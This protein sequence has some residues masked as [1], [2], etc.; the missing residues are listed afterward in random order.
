MYLLVLPRRKQQPHAFPA[1]VP[2]AYHQRG[3]P[4]RQGQAPV[5]CHAAHGTLQSATHSA[6]HFL[7]RLGRDHHG[8]AKP[9]DTGK[10]Q[11]PT[12]P[13]TS[14]AAAAAT[15]LRRGGGTGGAARGTVLVLV[16]VVVVLV[17]VLVVVVVVVVVIASL[18]HR[19]LSRSHRRRLDA[20][21]E[22][23]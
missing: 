6:P 8:G 11:Q 20:V 7:R 21:E 10:R 12:G 9:R 1:P 19:H 2:R 18:L 22:R 13:A 5:R 4:E 16:V 23:G 17:L 15:L 3:V 14:A